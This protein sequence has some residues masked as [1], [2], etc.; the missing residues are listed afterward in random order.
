MSIR[1]TIFLPGFIAS[2]AVVLTLQAPDLAYGAQK[3]KRDIPVGVAKAVELSSTIKIKLPG[4]VI[5]WAITHI[6]AEID[7]RVM[8]LHIKDGQRVKGG[9]L[10]AQ[11]RTTPLKLQL[12]L[13]KAQ[14]K[15]VNAKLEELLTGTRKESVDAAK[16]LFQQA[17]ARV[18]LAEAFLHRVKK[19]ADD[20][21]V[22]QG[23][24]DGA[25]AN[26][27]E[28]RAK[29]KEQQA[30]L[31]QLSEGPRIEKINQERA[32]LE[33]AE[34]RINI[35]QDEI[36]RASI[37]APFSGY[38]IK[39]QTEVGQWLE[40]GDPAVSMISDKS[41]K[42]EVDLPQSYFSKV[43]VGS[44]AKISLETYQSDKALKTFEATVIEKIPAGDP[45]S[46]AFPVRI[47]IHK[48]DK[49]I[50][51]GMLVN[52]EIYTKEKSKKM[53]YVPKDAVVR[54]PM[55]AMVW[56]VR[57]DKDKRMITHKVLV[58]TGQFDGS[59]VAIDFKG[60]QIISGDLV[61]VQGNER[62]K[63]NTQVMIIKHLN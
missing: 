48:P 9:Q 31:D 41:L 50:A 6:A 29:L 53:I 61:V 40:K 1:E 36:K 22:S 34:A 47:K 23:E 25:K 12:E 18:E 63:P 46:R 54:T 11:M 10:L 51:V 45:V 17:K 7:G 3:P 42:V 27:D 43:R 5:P 15:L 20:G 60:N 32:N 55:E 52:V 35:T 16:Y 59:L 49:S 58:K 26:A 56:L 24:Y 19:L 2:L 8:K 37:Y 13:A 38:I 21:V 14:K 30:I 33:A 28:A 57:P 39:R 4:T 44:A 62:L